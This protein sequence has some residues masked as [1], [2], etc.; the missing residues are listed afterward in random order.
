MRLEFIS[1]SEVS[2]AAMLPL[3][4]LFS[5]VKIY[6]QEEFICLDKFQLKSHV[7]WFHFGEEVDPNLRKLS[8]F[9][10]SFK[11]KIVIVSSDLIN[12]D[13]K[14]NSYILGTDLYLYFNMPK[15]EFLARLKALLR[16]LNRYVSVPIEINSDNLNLTTIE[17]RLLELFTNNPNKTLKKEEILN[18]V[19][20]EDV[21]KEESA[22]TVYIHRL[23]EKLAKKFGKTDIIENKRGY[24]YH[25]NLN[26]LNKNKA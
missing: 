2:E 14:E 19:W 6:S 7:F 24:G 3:K 11:N 13:L 20:N 16:S 9:R 18:K 15:R 23:R 17:T 1:N 4:Q 5:P 21:F 10:K 8:N 25:L 22:V 12:H 26:K